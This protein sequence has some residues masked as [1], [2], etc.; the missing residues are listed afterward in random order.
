MVIQAII[1]LIVFVLLW[2]WIPFSPLKKQ[3]RSDIELLRKS[4][5]MDEK[6]IFQASDFAELPAAIRK[7][8]DYCGYIGTEKMQ[9][10]CMEY[11]N[12][13]FKQGREGPSLKID[14]TQYNFVSEPCRMAFIDSRMF[15][16]PFEG[17]DI[18]QDGK[19]KMKG[20]IAKVFTLFDQTG[21]EMDKACLVTFLAESLFIPSILL[22][23]YI[24][25][26]EIDEY[27]VRSSIMFKGQTVSGIFSFNE[28][29]EFVSFTT[30][31]RAVVNKDG[32]I[33]NIPWTA[34]CKSYKTYEN[35]IKYPSSFAAI[36][37]YPEEDFIY[38]DGQINRIQL[39]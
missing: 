25:F 36:W 2:F 33:E 35:G 16:I 18:Y 26:E 8:L 19:G 13:N 32:T 7:Y 37:N 30:D 15:G 39:D 34:S 23:E 3:F 31:D 11:K 20:V 28:K 21:L 17:Y 22:Q 9:S 5:A 27:R 10:L 6:G 1:F 12:V 29:Y 4:N 24:S 38:F 14:Y